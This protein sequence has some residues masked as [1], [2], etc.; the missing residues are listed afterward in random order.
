MLLLKAGCLFSHLA[1]DEERLTEAK[2][3]IEAGADCSIVNKVSFHFMH[4]LC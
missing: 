2:L 1:C 4:S 3:L